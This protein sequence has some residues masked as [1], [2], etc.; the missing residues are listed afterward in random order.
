MELS[1]WVSE[2]MTIL[3]GIPLVLLALLMP[4]LFAKRGQRNRGQI[5]TGGE[6][7]Y[8]PTVPDASGSADTN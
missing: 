1:T 4:L 5:S 7:A 6:S 3:V 8:V 2:N